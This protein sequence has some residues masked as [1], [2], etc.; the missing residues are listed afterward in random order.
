MHSKRSFI[1]I[2][3][4]FGAIYFPLLNLVFIFLKLMH[5][6]DSTSMGAEELI[7][8]KE[9]SPTILPF[10]NPLVS[11]PLLTVS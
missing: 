7:R 4:V 2:S 3:R 9:Q 10:A 11:D 5:V 1:V 6:P 8:K